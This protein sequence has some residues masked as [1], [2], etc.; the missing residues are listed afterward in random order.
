[1][2]LL[3]YLAGKDVV[4]ITHWHLAH[5]NP[6]DRLIREASLQLFRKAGATVRA[7]VTGDAVLP[8]RLEM[9]PTTTLVISGGGN[10]GGYFYPVDGTFGMRVADLYPE[11][12]V[13]VLPQTYVTPWN[14]EDRKLADRVFGRPNVDVWLRDGTSWHYFNQDYHKGWV[15]PDTVMDHY[16]IPV[17]PKAYDLLSLR[18]QDGESVMFFPGSDWTDWSWDELVPQIGKYRRVLTDRLHVAI[19]AYRLQCDVWLVAN[20]YYK[21]AAYFDLWWKNSSQVHFL[22]CQQNV[23]DFLRD[24]YNA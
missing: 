6:G 15:E 17:V 11:H 10:L 8:V 2:P 18:R 19:L 5:Q 13:V 16:E 3:D 9:D 24:C 7:E 12:R 1:M 14:E 4:F 20:A 23:D 22:N 21:N